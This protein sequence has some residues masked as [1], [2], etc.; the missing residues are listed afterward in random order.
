VHKG[1]VNGRVLRMNVDAEGTVILLDLSPFALS[2]SKG[3]RHP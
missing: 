3:L 2:L 1:K